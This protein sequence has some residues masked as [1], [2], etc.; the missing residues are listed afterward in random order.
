MMVE[1]PSTSLPGV[2][3]FTQWALDNLQGAHD[4]IIKSHVDQMVQANKLRL[5]DLSKL[6]VGEFAYLSTK[7]LN[8]LQG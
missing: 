8:L 6:K 7:E 2:R 1:I 5:P 4:M 3:D